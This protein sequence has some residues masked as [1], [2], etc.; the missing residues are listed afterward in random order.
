M[1]SKECSLYKTARRHNK[2]IEKH[3][4]LKEIDAPQNLW[5]SE[6]YVLGK[7]VSKNNTAMKSQLKHSFKSLI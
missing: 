2:P 4:C 7:I 1:L 5:G 3:E 6:S